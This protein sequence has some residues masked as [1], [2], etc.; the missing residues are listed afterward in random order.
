VDARTADVTL[1]ANQNNPLMQS[2]TRGLRGRILRELQVSDLIV[3][4]HPKLDDMS[5][6]SILRITQWSFSQLP[7]LSS[8]QHVF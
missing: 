7:L 8:S 2:R 6:T 3:E 5:C 1:S 4:K